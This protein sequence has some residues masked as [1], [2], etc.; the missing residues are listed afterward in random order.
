MGKKGEGMVSQGYFREQYINVKRKT[1]CG[2]VSKIR[3]KAIKHWG[4]GVVL[5]I[6]VNKGNSIDCQHF[7]RAECQMRK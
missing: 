2:N 4:W 5:K 7:E 6:N 3:I 1:G